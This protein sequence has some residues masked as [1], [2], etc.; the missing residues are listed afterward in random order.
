MRALTDSILYKLRYPIGYVAIVSLIAIIIGL[1]ALTAPNALR[2]GEM[3]STVASASLSTSSMRPSMIIDLPYHVLQRI[4]FI[5]FDVST[6]T[7]K[8]PSLVLGTLTV[9]GVFFLTNLWFRRN[10]AVVATILSA[11]S[12]L[13][14][15]L[16]QDGTPAIS[17][18]FVTIWLLL[19]GTLV[20]RNYAFNTLW[21]VL[22]CVLLASA[23]YVPLGI[24]LVITVLVTAF[25]HPHIRYIIRKISRL[26]LVLALSLGVLVVTP[27]IYACIVDL[28]TLRSLLGINPDNFNIGQ[29]L[30]T[31]GN[32]LLGFTV[33]STSSMLQPVF[34][35]GLSMLIATGLYNMARQHHTARSYVVIILSSV[36]LPLFV[37]DPEHIV[38][39]F[40]VASILIAYGMSFLIFSWYGLFPRNPYARVAG[41]IPLGV[42]TIGLVYSG[43]TRYM[44]S[45]TYNV[46]VLRH[47][48]SDL[49]L[50]DRT[51]NDIKQES[52]DV[53]PVLVVAPGESSFYSAYAR[54]DK[55]ISLDQ[56]I[57]AGADTIILTRSAARTDALTSYTLNRIITNHH[58]NDS[59]RLYIYKTIAK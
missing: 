13:F 47:Y 46:D 40:P 54:Y 16:L 10:I 50:V 29:H 36:L 42:L 3:E 34:S 24:Y 18:S 41:L 12:T 23:L 56:Q 48:S 39:A 44:Y 11:T 45:Y 52:K 28:T 21:K 49:K 7:I 53:K 27:L 8:L 22:V 38:A 31:L 6:L 26:R 9:V 2:V 37:V 55:R 17:F 14:L 43:L 1:A 33:P 5:L 4:G 35:L 30:M 51:I 58:T 25:L 15:F 32:L 57:P 19:S 59:D 20:T